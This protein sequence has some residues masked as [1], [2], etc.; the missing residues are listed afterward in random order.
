MKPLP[1][2]T[3]SVRSMDWT[4]VWARRGFTPFGAVFVRAF[5]TVPTSPV[6][7]NSIVHAVHIVRAKMIHVAPF[8]DGIRSWP[9]S[10]LTSCLF[11]ITIGIMGGKLKRQEVYSGMGCG[12]K[13]VLW[14]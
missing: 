2:S 9:H 3:I 14:V 13:A 8:V 6:S 4:G 11:Y 5:G 12:R 10:K 7:L 1:Q